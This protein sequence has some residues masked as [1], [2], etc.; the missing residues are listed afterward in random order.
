MVI[1]FLGNDYFKISSGETTVLV[2]PENQR[3]VRGAIL[4]LNTVMPAPVEE[5]EDGP[6]V[7]SHQGEY[8][9]QGIHI[10]GWSGGN[11]KGTERTIYKMEMEGVTFAIL[12]QITKEPESKIQEFLADCDVLIVPSGGKPFM[13]AGATAKLVR[14]LEPSVVLVSFPENLKPLL[15]EI[16]QEKC[17]PEEKFVFKKKDLTPKAMTVKCLSV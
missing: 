2:D 9:V 16:G 6:T 13:E 11:E 14:Q 10:T 5:A 12:G 17:V 3:S 1:N 8:E 15:K 4:I 7:I